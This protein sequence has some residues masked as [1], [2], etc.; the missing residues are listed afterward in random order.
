MRPGHHET[1]L[2]FL[3][4]LDD[5]FILQQEWGGN[6]GGGREGVKA[7]RTD[8]KLNIQSLSGSL[9]INISSDPTQSILVLALY[10]IIYSFNVAM[11]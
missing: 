7:T 4:Q 10:V 9:E 6:E 8:A 11:L 2:K 5:Y 3:N 1:N